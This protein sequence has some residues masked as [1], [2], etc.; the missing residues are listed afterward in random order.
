MNDLGKLAVSAVL[1]ALLALTV[2]KRDPDIAMVIVLAAG[3]VLLT[4]ALRY[5]AVI[6]DFWQDLAALSDASD[7]AAGTLFRAVGISVMIHL[8]ASFCRDSG[9]SG[10]AAKLELCGSAACVLLMIPLLSDM[11]RLISGML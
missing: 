10:L 9:E 4:A 2:R 3:T 11:L 6:A 7:R 8:A 5:L 1:A